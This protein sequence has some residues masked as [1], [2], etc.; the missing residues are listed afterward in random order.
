[1]E[2]GGGLRWS[3]EGE[4]SVWCGVGA[5]CQVSGVSRETVKRAIFSLCTQ[6]IF[7]TT[8]YLV[9]EYSQMSKH[10]T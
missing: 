10:T 7:R 9:P 2:E 4:V 3:E 8:H 5:R 1:V 6:Y